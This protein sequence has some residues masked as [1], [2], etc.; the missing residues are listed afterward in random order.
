MGL[1]P[2]KDRVEYFNERGLLH[3]EDGPAYEIFRWNKTRGVQQWHIEGKFHR[4]DGPALIR[5]FSKNRIQNEI[6][7]KH[8]VKHREGGPAEASY[9]YGK[10]PI[11]RILV[12]YKNGVL[13]RE[14]GP[15]HQVFNKNGTLDLEEWIYEDHSHRHDGPAYSKYRRGRLDLQ[16][17]RFMHVAHRWDGPVEEWYGGGDEPSSSDNDYYLFGVNFSKDEFQEIVS[18]G[19]FEA[20]K[21]LLKTLDPKSEF[22][23]P[24]LYA[25]SKFLEDYDPVLA[26]SIRATSSLV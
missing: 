10:T 7:Y 2:F 12:W 17:W 23:G 20:A 13:H 11:P 24:T 26:Y 25:L 21:I 15:A 4:E 18:K 19:K 5:Y 1:G 8:G 6:W 22:A 3:K 14:D 16:R 9:F